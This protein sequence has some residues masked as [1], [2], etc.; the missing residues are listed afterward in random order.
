MN[1]E[2]NK[3]EYGQELID[4]SKHL[5]DRYAADFDTLDNKALGVIGIAGL[6]I[7]FQALNID[8]TA[9]IVKCFENGFCWL[10]FLAL[11]AL[12]IHAFFLILCILKALTAFQIVDFEYP[13][14][15]DVMLVNVKDKQELLHNIINT[16]K[17]TTKS[18]EQVNIQKAK[19]LEKS[20]H[21]IIR[22]IISL[23]VFIFLMILIKSK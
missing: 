3:L 6:L 17:E 13:G 9:E 8:T 12:V 21:F 19:A 5:F 4:Y 16:Y 20:V 22:A 18:I 2:E 15:V 7:G 14:D 23:I 10:P 11:V 1:D